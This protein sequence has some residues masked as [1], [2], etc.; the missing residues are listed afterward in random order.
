M[1]TSHNY[2]NSNQPVAVSHV[3]PGETW[4]IAGEKIHTEDLFVRLYAQK[5]H[6]GARIVRA[7]YVVVCR[8]NSPKFAEINRFGVSGAVALETRR[9]SRLMETR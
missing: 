8:L 5:T 1:A 7:T 9:H 2:Y 6:L 3:N 4:F